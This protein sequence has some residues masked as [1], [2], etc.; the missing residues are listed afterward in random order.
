MLASLPY[1]LFGWCGRSEK[2]K[3]LKYHCSVLVFQPA[4]SLTMVVLALGTFR[5]LSEVFG[6]LPAYLKAAASS[7]QSSC[8]FFG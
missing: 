1:G 6:N 8:A 4:V 3:G 5:H 7:L 2:G